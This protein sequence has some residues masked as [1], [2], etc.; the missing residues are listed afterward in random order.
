MTIAIDYDG[1]YTADPILWNSFIEI[2]VLRGHRV[3]CVTCRPQPEDWREHDLVLMPVP[4]SRHVFTD[5]AAKRWYCENLGLSIDVW[6]D[7]MPETI[8]Q[9]R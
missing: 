6:I 9:G 7:D 1:T 4:K 3:F 2:A 5:R 8:T